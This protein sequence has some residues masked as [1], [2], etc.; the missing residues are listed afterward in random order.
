VALGIKAD[1]KKVDKEEAA[2]IIRAW[3]NL[4]AER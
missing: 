4:Y 1:G 3:Q 2:L